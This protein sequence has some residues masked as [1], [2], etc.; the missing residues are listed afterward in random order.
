MSKIDRA[1]CEYE[2]ISNFPDIMLSGGE[3]SFSDHNSILISLTKFEHGGPKPFKFYNAWMDHLEFLKFVKSEQEKL[4]V[5]HV[6]VKLKRL[7]KSYYRME[8]NML[9]GY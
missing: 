8:Q 6:Q 1:M 3:S 4:N 2:W 5:E 7:K 9:W